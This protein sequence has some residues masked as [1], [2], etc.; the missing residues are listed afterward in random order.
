MQ[1]DALLTFR[2]DL[3]SVDIPL[4]RCDF[5]G[6]FQDI[7]VTAFFDIQ[8]SASD[9]RMQRGNFRYFS[10]RLN[11]LKFEFLPIGQLLQS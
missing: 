8:A 6:R 4:I 7:D 2:V 1:T 11:L 10:F 3:D 9:S 5:V